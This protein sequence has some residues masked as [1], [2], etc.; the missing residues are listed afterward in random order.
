MA[1]PFWHDVDIR[2]AGDVYYKIFKSTNVEHSMLISEISD[3][4]KN[5]TNT[6]FEGDMMIVAAWDHVPQ[7]PYTY[8]LKYANYYSYGFQQ[9][10]LNQVKIE[11]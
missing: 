10:V 1:A 11:M 3:F 7:Y 6:S 4:V 5:K 8:L 2:V 9:A